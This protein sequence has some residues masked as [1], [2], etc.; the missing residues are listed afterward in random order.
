MSSSSPME[1]TCQRVMDVRQVFPWILIVVWVPALI[2]SRPKLLVPGRFARLPIAS[3]LLLGWSGV[4]SYRSIIAA[5]PS[6]SL[7]LLA[8]GGLLYSA[9]VAFHLWEKLRFQ[10][11]IWH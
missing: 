8:I 10:N 7:W 3:Y 9:G 2:G 1:R 4:L 5:L 11:V 6:S